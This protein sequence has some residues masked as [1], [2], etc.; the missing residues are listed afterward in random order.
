MDLQRNHVFKERTTYREFVVGLFMKA[1]FRSKQLG[2]TLL[3]L[4]ILLDSVT[5]HLQD[6]LFEK[7][8]DRTSLR[9]LSWLSRP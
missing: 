3:V 7:H 8:K 4:Y 6:V 2:A 1:S 9:P 5:P